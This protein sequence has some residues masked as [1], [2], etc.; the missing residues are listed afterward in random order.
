MSAINVVFGAVL[1]FFGRSLYWL[2]VG[3]AGFLAGV[4]LADVV[5]ADQSQVIRVLAAVAAG[6]LGALVAML[7]Q[8]VGFALAEKRAWQVADKANTK[9]CR[10]RS[11]ECFC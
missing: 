1:L 8:R 10:E 5:L 11:I 2:F 3:I 7:A 6:A 4:Q 9:D